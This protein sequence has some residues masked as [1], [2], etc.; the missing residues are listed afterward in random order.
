MVSL[1]TPSNNDFAGPGWEGGAVF[2]LL[3]GVG[4]LS[5]ATIAAT[6]G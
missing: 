5:V 3:G 6:A 2:V 1:K 4:N